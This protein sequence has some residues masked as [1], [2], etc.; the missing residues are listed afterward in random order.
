MP[1][2]GMPVR[3]AECG[4]Y[5]L[6]AFVDDK[7]SETFRIRA[8][9]L[10]GGLKPICAAATNMG[11]AAAGHAAPVVFCPP[12]GVRQCAQCRNGRRSHRARA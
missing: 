9:S 8:M 10:A 2:S 12:V 4:G 11:T 6:H 7:T 1:Y 3:S 5:V